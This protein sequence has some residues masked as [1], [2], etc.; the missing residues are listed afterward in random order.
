MAIAFS[1]YREALE[2]RRELAKQN[3]ATFLPDVATTL[4]NL[5][6]LHQN[7]N[8]MAIALSEYTEALEIYQDFAKKSPAAFQPKVEMV[9]KNIAILAI[10]QNAAI[11]P[12]LNEPLT[13]EERLA[14]FDPARHGGEVMTTSQ[15]LGAEQW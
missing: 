8:E 14:N 1:E 11:A 4:N 5:A 9:L 15:S 7:I 2:I 13:L 10:L 6:N 12:M 3:P